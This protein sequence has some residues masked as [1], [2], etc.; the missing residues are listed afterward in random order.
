MNKKKG[1]TNCDHVMKVFKYQIENFERI[2]KGICFPLM[3]WVMSKVLCW[4][5]LIKYNLLIRWIMRS[6]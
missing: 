4:H 5:Y 6:H 3:Y 2:L 1:K